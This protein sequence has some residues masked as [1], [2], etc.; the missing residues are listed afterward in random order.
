MTDDDQPPAGP[1]EERL[2]AAHRDGRQALCLSLLREADLALP[3]TA[4]AAGG[5][6]RPAWATVAD[7]A[8]T[9]LLAYTSVEAMRLAT[10][11]VATYCRI[12][13]M[14]EL[15]AGWPDP[16][17][18]LAV[19]AGLRV[20][21]LLEP[22]TV[23]RLAV[24]SMA[25]DLQLDP[26]AGVPAVQKLLAS[27]DLPDLL[28]EREPRV[29]GYC[30]HA[31]DVSHIATPAV[32]AAALGRADLLTGSGSLN[33]LRWRPVG[34]GLYRTPYGG[35]DEESRAA[36]EGWVVE[37]PPFAGMGLVPGGDNVIR[38]YK[39]YG[40]GLPHGAEIW[41]LTNAGTEHRRA[42]YHGDL[43][44]WLLIGRSS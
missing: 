5:A 10:G 27:A 13:S 17:W 6:E 22:G 39:V 25:Q 24:P 9:W 16:R 38:E 15:A 36:V 20:A 29:S 41:E 44:R 19:N 43:R 28:G 23:A 3:I 40:V 37:E 2:W 21:F 34:L 33:I 12:S 14:P 8:R 7:A 35:I 26:E 18:G 30:H 11:G 1:F 42:M 4:A 32:L 31:L